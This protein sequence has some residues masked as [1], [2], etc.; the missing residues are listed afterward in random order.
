MVTI[1]KDALINFYS[2]NDK[3]HLFTHQIQGVKSFEQ[4]LINDSKS[5]VLIRA[6][7]DDPS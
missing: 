2:L 3:R 4:I 5:K 7:V 1:G 6:T